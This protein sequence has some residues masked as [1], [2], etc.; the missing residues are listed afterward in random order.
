VYGLV[1]SGLDV[2]LAVAPVAF[3]ALLDR[4]MPSAVFAGVAATLVCAI[5]AALCLGHEGRGP[6]DQIFSSK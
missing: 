3:G 4:Q 2:G 5:V 6:R 1:Y